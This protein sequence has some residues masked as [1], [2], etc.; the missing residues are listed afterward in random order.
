MAITNQKK[1]KYDE[2]KYYKKE[3]NLKETERIWEPEEETALKKR[4]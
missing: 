1:W 3:K 4:V 2:K